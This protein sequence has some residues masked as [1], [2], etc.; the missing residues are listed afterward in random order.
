M[1]AD[2]QPLKWATCR[3]RD[4][5]STSAL[6][7][8]DDMA[9]E[10][11]NVHFFEGGLCTKRAGS[12]STGTLTGM[13]GTNAICGWLPGQDETARELLLIDDAATN[14]IR[15]IAAGSTV[16]AALTLPQNIA[17][18]NDKA[19]S[20]AVSNGKIV[21]AY[22][23]SQN[24]LPVY[25]PNYNTTVM[26]FMGMGTPAAPTLATTGG[27]G[28]TFT[29][30]YRVAFTEQRSGVTVRRGN[31]SAS[32][33]L[34]ITDDTS[35]RVTKPA[36][37]SEG[38][39]HW[40]IY[41]QHT[42]GTYY[43]IATVAIGT[44]TYDDASSTVSTTTAAPEEGANTP[45]PSVKYVYSDGHR[46]YGFGVWE[47]AAGDSHTPRDGTLYFSPVLDTSAIHDDERVSNTTSRIGRIAVSRNAGGVDR[48]LNGLGNTVYA[49]QSQGIYTFQP[50][51]N[52]DVPLRRV[53]IS[54]KRGALTNESIVQAIDEQGRPALYFLDPALGPYRIGRDGLQWCGKDMA[55]I[56]ATVNKG[57]TNK[58]AHATYYED[59]YQIWFWIATG[60]ENDPDK[61]MVFDCTLGRVDPERPTDGVRGGWSLFTGDMAKC[62]CS[63]LMSRTLGASM[64]RDLVPYAGRATGTTLLKC[65]TGTDDAGTT[66][67]GYLE[68]KAFEIEPLYQHKSLT[69]AYVL[70]EAVVMNLRL[71]LVRNTGDD[72]DRTSDIVLSAVSDGGAETE[73]LKQF[74]DAALAD[75]FTFQARLGDSGAASD[76]WT[77]HR[78]YALVKGAE[79]R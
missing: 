73:V 13:S 17:T 78:F 29:G 42:T 65:D 19:I 79:D 24:R 31:L 69:K 46:L 9:R 39:T 61:I 7:I 62:R 8:A 77:L 50:T 23:S 1:A 71:S 74:E 63:T 64:S 35:I 27:A 5:W 32:A 38:E 41:R 75:A 57:A 30:V 4:G 34:S 68:S 10:A 45:W 22:D 55:D 25:D 70:A 36:T 49:F 20:F 26:R 48:G 51:G 58:V 2:G 52:D 56:W 21:I 47:T 11:L 43:L 72:T 76:A 44:T 6:D 67:Q 60:A 40:E 16:S 14:T 59:V 33:T 53:T 15:R 12:T 18:A 28:L 37:I 54:A 66:F 3:G